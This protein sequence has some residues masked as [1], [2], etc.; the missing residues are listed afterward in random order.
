MRGMFCSWLLVQESMTNCDLQWREVPYN[1]E[2]GCQASWAKLKAGHVS[3]SI[4]LRNGYTRTT[5]W[6]HL[7]T[8]KPYIPV[9]SVY[10]SWTSLG[11]LGAV[12]TSVSLI[13]LSTPPASRQSFSVSLNSTWHWTITQVAAMNLDP[14]L[15]F[16]ARTHNYSETSYSSLQLTGTRVVALSRWSL[17]LHAYRYGLSSYMASKRK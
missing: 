17:L 8:Q 14:C 13:S 7:Q 2:E 3:A 4:F 6:T 1:Y 11:A 16:L 9:A 5:N 15:H 12:S 10:R